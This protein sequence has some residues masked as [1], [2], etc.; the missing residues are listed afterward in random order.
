MKS[1]DLLIELRS[2]EL[3][4]VE[5]VRDYLQLHFEDKTLTCYIWPLLNRNGVELSVDDLNYKN[6][7]CKCIGAKVDIIELVAKESLTIALDQGSKIILNLDPDNPKI[8]GEIAI[9]SDNDNNWSVL[10]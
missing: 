2:E 1:K 7:L 9:L 4:S 3:S 8:V 6:E 5:F 10:E